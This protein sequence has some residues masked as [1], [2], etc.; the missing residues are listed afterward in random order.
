MEKEELEQVL[1]EI[2]EEYFEPENIGYEIDEAGLVIWNDNSTSDLAFSPL[3]RVSM[4]Q[5][6][7]HLGC[8]IRT[9]RNGK[10]RIH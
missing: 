1:E 3:I 5:V 2:K 6:E 7:E 8:C 4:K 10:L 9:T